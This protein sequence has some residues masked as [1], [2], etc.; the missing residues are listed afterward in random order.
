MQVVSTAF[1][2]TATALDQIREKLSAALEDEGIDLK[3]FGLAP[4][5][6]EPEADTETDPPSEEA[7]EEFGGLASS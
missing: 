2:A 7:A 5:E 1:G 3:T 4:P 6:E